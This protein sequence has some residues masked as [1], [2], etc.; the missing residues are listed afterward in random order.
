MRKNIL[1]MMTKKMMKTVTK[2]KMICKD[3]GA[4]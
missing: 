4:V 2:I 1:P 3:E